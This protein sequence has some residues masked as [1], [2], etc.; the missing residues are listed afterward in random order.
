MPVGCRRDDVGR[1]ILHLG[2]PVL[3]GRKFGAEHAH[4]LPVLVVD[5]DEALRQP[6]DV[7][8]GQH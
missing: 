1:Q 8:F 4:E 6:E 7:G 2:F 5:R 3:D